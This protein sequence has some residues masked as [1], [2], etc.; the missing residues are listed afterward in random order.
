MLSL[1]CQPFE[2][3]VLFLVVL[4]PDLHLGLR[5]GDE[6]VLVLAHLHRVS[7]VRIALLA[8]RENH[9]RHKHRG[10]E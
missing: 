6:S 10:I 4:D 8:V 9:V 7:V 1:F 5:M 3:F 2:T